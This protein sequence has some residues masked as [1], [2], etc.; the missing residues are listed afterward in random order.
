VI[1]VLPLSDSKA[2]LSGDSEPI[3]T[4][5]AIAAEDGSLTCVHI[6]WFN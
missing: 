3:T 1:V 4:I 5:D 6:S 2:L